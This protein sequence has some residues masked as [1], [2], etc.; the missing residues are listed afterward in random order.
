MSHLTLMEQWLVSP[1]LRIHDTVYRKTG[2]L[3]GHN[4]PGIPPSLLL[5]TI[6]AKTSQLRSTT[7]TYAK[8]GDSYL[9]VASYGGNPK[10]PGWY[11]NLAKRAECEVNVGV[12][13]IS[14]TARKVTPGDAD[15][16]RLWTIVNQNNAY[17]YDRYQSR[18][19]RPIPIFALTPG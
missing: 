7:L 8:D 16:A 10:Y 1:L 14:V 9:V 3:I 4:I 12:K 6:G 17:R 15:Y 5:R 19:P 2:G 13:R 11:H 18:T